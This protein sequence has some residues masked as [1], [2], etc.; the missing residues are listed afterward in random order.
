METEEKKFTF[1]Q[2]MQLLTTGFEWE[3]GLFIE[4]FKI[5][6]ER[7]SREEAKD[8]LG[9]AMY[10]AGYQLGV[11]ATQFAGSLDPKGMAQ[12][13]DSIYGM[14]SDIAQKLDE[15]QFI[16]RGQNCA[17]FNLFKR[18]GVSM[19]DIRFICDAYCVGDVG[20][21][22]GFSSQMHFQHTE[23]LMFGDDGCVWEYSC[24][25]QPASPSAVPLPE[26]E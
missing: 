3:A 2:G 21:A 16:I 18:W 9:Q 19:E 1:S 24:S 17:A 20:Q 11:D 13:W 4:T 7:L 26:S 25:P 6:S 5:L 12:A 8:I 10:R 14:G 23:R 15:E 22:E